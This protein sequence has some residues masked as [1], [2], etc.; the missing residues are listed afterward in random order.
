[1]RHRRDGTEKS[2]KIDK[3]ALRGKDQTIRV[4]RLRRILIPIRINKRHQWS[5]T[6][7]E[8]SSL[9]SKWNVALG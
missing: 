6:L 4:F 8:L 3:E 9:R 7:E 2:R 1:M 5:F